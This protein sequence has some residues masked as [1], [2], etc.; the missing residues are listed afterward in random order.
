MRL[1]G[2][3]REPPFDFWPYF[4]KIPKEDFEGY[5]CTAGNVT[6]VWEDPSAN[7]QHV[8]INSN[9]TNVFK[10]LILDLKE[11]CVLGHRLLNIASEYGLN[12]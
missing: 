2:P 12:S 1:L 5:D 9:D 3:D 8:L 11:K 4:E 6:Y 10:V 7:F